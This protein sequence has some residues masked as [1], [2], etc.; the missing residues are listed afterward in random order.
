MPPFC[1]TIPFIFWTV[2]YTSDTNGLKNS[3]CTPSNSSLN[4]EPGTYTVTTDP[5]VDL[6]VWSQVPNHYETY[7]NSS[8]SGHPFEY[9]APTM[10]FLSI[11][12]TTATLCKL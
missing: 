3:C 1:V 4:V 6:Q 2:F 12:P 5:I 11:Y 8:F 10:M 7:I 9:K